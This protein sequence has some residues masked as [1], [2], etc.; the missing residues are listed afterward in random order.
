MAFMDFQGLILAFFDSVW[1][2][3]GL[4]GVAGGYTGMYGAAKSSMG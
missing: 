2:A 4:H 1:F 3:W